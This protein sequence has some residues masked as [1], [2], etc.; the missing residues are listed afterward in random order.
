MIANLQYFMAEI[1]HVEKYVKNLQHIMLL[2]TE[3]S[4]FKKRFCS[5]DEI[6]SVNNRFFSPP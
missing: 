3:I 1:K 6:K 5:F 4:C 2:Y